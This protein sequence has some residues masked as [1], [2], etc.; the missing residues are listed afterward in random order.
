M[1]W[2]EIVPQLQYIIL[3]DIFVTSLAFLQRHQFRNYQ[4]PIQPDG[5][6]VENNHTLS[7]FANAKSKLLINLT[8]TGDKTPVSFDA[9]IYKASNKWSKAID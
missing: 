9:Y 6:K 2:K 7:K 3:H 5:E 1:A 4:E 8:I